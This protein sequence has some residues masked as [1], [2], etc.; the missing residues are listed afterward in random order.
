MTDEGKVSKQV[1]QAT[2]G[3]LREKQ[4]NCWRLK[5]LKIQ[6]ILLFSLALRGSIAIYVSRHWASMSILHYDFGSCNSLIVNSSP[7]ELNFF[8]QMGIIFGGNFPIEI[9]IDPLGNHS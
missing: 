3:C 7:K 6:I 2:L 1:M 9:M 5:L 4:N 8:L